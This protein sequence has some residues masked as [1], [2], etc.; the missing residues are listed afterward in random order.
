[1]G[2]RL[3]LL[4]TNFP[5]TL[6]MSTYMG[7]DEGE[8]CEFGLEFHDAICRRGVRPGETGFLVVHAFAH[9]FEHFIQ[10]ALPRHLG[11]TW[12]T[13]AGKAYEPLLLGAAV[14]LVEWFILWW[15]YRKKIFLKI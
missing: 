1:M 13:F 9:L 4:G 15:M 12:F 2:D 7:Y 8:A 3:L 11:D 10:S 6:A 5:A 14:L